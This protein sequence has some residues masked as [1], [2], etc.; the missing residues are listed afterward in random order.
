MIKVAYLSQNTNDFPH[1]Y[2]NNNDGIFRNVHFVDTKNF[3]PTD[4]N[5]SIDY[6]VSNIEY[7]MDD[8]SA[9][10]AP[11]NLWLLLGEPYEFPVD[12]CFQGRTEFG[13]VLSCLED[14]IPNG[15]LMP[16][17]TQS[18]MDTDTI[19][20]LKCLSNPE[21]HKPLCWITSKK[22]YF[23][24]H[25]QRL[26][27]VYKLQKSGI[28]D[29]YGNGFEFV[30]NKI[31]TLSNYKY[32][33]AMEN[34][35]D[36]HY[37]TEKPMDCWLAY[38]MPLYIGSGNLGKYFPEKSFIALDIDDKFLLDKIKEISESDLHL[39]CQPYIKEARQIVMNDM[40]M[41]SLLAD[42][43]QHHYTTTTPSP[44]KDISVQGVKTSRFL[45]KKILYRLYQSYYNFLL[46]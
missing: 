12:V 35:I 11:E 19:P 23:K 36:N 2:S 28:C 45:P 20:Q 4:S 40:N 13:K 29:L 21:K 24:G 27:L 14:K 15:D 38:T 25:M 30:D 7:A 39:E 31:A 18:W 16:I 32:S 34:T 33:I 8:F 22:I 41:F 42:K 1:R 9:Y 46:D 37:I 44:K 10:V 3:D 43:I 5:H 17:C 26:A 6:I